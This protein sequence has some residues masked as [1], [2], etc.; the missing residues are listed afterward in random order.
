MIVDSPDRVRNALRAA[1]HA[2]HQRVDALP[3]MRRLLDP[4]VSTEDYAWVIARLHALHTVLTVSITRA[5]DTYASE[6]LRVED[7]LPNLEADVEALSGA[8]TASPGTRPA[9]NLE[10]GAQALGAWYV[11][12]G[13]ALGGAL[14][15]KHL[16]EH[17]SS[18][19]PL[20]HF[21][22]SARGRWPRF[23]NHLSVAL[24]DDAALEDAIVGAGKAYRYVEQILASEPG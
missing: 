24:D 16:R 13:A 4:E 9:P 2:D 22:R 10:T 1:T 5:L 21:G 20:A 17:L 15:A 7:L 19:L 3:R 23:L 18:S 12:E 14:I 11:L 8:P 6:E